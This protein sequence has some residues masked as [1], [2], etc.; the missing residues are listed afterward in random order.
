MHR[1]GGLRRLEAL[2][3]DMH[4]YNNIFQPGKGYSYTDPEMV[5]DVALTLA[6]FWWLSSRDNEKQPPAAYKRCDFV[7]ADE[8]LCVSVP[9]F[10]K[11]G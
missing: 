11:W 7:Q 1:G 9:P 6:C 8:L 5:H 10:V 4:I 3:S 2:L